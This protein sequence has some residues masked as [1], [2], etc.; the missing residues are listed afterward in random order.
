MKFSDAMGVVLGVGCGVR[1]RV[2]LG[3][4]VGDGVAVGGAVSLGRGV[5]VGVGLSVGNTVSVGVE[6]GE[7]WV[8]P[9]HAVQRNNSAAAEIVARRIRSNPPVLPKPRASIP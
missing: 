6:V 8:K 7:V 1:V 5:R 9:L 3:V 2:A 4:S